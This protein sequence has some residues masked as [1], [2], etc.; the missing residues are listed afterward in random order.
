MDLWLL[1]NIVG[2]WRCAMSN[3][4]QGRF[5]L[6]GRWSTVWGKT[7]KATCYRH[8]RTSRR[9]NRII[10]VRPTNRE[11]VTPKPK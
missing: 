8:H 11:I 5:S 7:P 1:N 3:P 9:F 6:A 10:C 2:Q 4:C